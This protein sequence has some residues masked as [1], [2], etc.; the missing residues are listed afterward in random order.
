MNNINNIKISVCLASYN[1]GKYIREQIE[2]ILGQLSNQDELIISDDGSTDNTIEII[3]SFK[4]IRIKL[5]KNNFHNHINNFQFC[6]SQAKGKYIF[7]SDQ[8]DVWLENKVKIMT[9]YLNQYDLVCSNCHVVNKNLERTGS[10]FFTDS[11]NKK[12]GFF[13]NLLKNQYLGCCLAFNRKILNHALPF[14]KNLITHDT[15]IGL[16]AEIYG[17]TTFINDKLIL[18]RRHESNTSNTLKGSTLSFY[19]KIKYRMIIIGGLIR[20]FFK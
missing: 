20:N 3:Q 15:W 12:S 19:Q 1:G 8:D 6:L 17:K 5:F 9:E 2:S 10:F 16:T 7:L 14:P 18:F 4:D 11:P 13:K